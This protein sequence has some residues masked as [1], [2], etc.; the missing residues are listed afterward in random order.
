M[1]DR[2]ERRDLAGIL[3]AAMA[4]ALDWRLLALFA[5]T[6]LWTSVIA[7]L[8]AWR[9]MASAFDDSPRAQ[10]IAGAFDLLAVQDMGM[11]LVRSGAPVT[12]GFALAT[13][14]SVLSWPFLAAMA[15]GAASRGERSRTF[16]EV[17][18]WG[19]AYFVRMLRIGLVAIVPFALVGV[20]SAGVF[21]GAR[22][23]ARRAIVESQASLGWRIATLAV[24]AIFV[25]V[26]ATIEA[27]RAA[28]G[29][30]DE[31]RSGWSA[32]L[33]GV[34]LV[35]REPRRAMGAYLGATL[36]SYA[37]ALPLL[38]LRLRISGPSGVA[39]VAG[40]IVT[41]LAVASLGWGRATRLIALTAI[42]RA[43]SAANVSPSASSE[44]AHDGG[45]TVPSG[46]M[47]RDLGRR[48]PVARRG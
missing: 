16:A 34:K 48:K 36:A 40:F 30:D 13:L 39:L 6:A 46:S 26:H 3:R 19:I 33:R 10:E 2:P 17:L 7:T 38:V 20:A 45:Y 32:W 9:V 8:P 5:G 29:A 23:V 35:G 14:F 18:E 25:L 41:Q 28:Y 43:R 47:F 24:L 44:D 42:A 27:G 15:M 11:D 12:G 1:N 37:V 4:G 21:R 31:L 22:Q